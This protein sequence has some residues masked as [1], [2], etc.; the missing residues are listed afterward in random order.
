VHEAREQGDDAT[1]A[2]IA[3]RLRGYAAGRRHVEPE[4]APA[5]SASPAPR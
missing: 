2:D 1:A 5:K 3:Q 4:S